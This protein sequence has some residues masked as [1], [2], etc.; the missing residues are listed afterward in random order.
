MTISSERQP[1]LEARSVSHVYGAGDAR[2]QALHDVS[3]VVNQGEFL[4]VLGPSGSGKSTLLAILSGLL[5]PTSG[6]VWA[7]GQNLGALSEQQLEE[8]RRRYCAFIFAEY[9]LV[10]SL[11]ARQQLEII[12]CWGQGASA[13]DARRRA[14]AMLAQLGLGKKTTLRPQQLSGGEQQRVA[15]ARGLVKDALFC[16][17]DE[18]TAALDWRNGQQVVE[19]LC[20]VAHEHD[21]A[22]LVTAHDERIVPYADR[23][24]LLDEGRLCVAGTGT[25]RDASGRL[26]GQR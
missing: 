19:L 2:V 11:N 4:L 22:V 25:A 23:V 26:V 18:P 17:A 21:A 20:Q 8:F 24:L 13:Q 3:L 5:R 10:P 6:E 7:L 1:I 15:I 16:F 14:E 12:L 9:N